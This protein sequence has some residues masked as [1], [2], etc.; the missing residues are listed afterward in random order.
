M[1][2]V[3][4]VSR[5]ACDEEELHI[6]LRQFMRSKCPDCGMMMGHEGEPWEI[7]VERHVDCPSFRVPRLG[8]TSKE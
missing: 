7:T 3:N 1:A 4:V 2:S 6:K 5:V 8:I